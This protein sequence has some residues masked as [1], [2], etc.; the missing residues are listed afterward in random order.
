MGDMISQS[1][2]QLAGLTGDQGD[3]GRILAEG[4]PG[5]GV[6]VGVGPPSEA[7]SGSTS[8]STS[9]STWASSGGGDHLAELE[10]LAKLRD[11]GSLTDAEFG[12]QKAK[13]IGS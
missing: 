3:R 7:R 2:E 1:N 12:Q 9:S 6:I 11:S 4:I 10:R 5:Q 13:M 8:T